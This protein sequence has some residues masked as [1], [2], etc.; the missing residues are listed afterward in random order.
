MDPDQLDALISRRRLAAAEREN[1]RLRDALE[2]AAE[3]EATLR[4]IAE[5]AEKVCNTAF[6]FNVKGVPQQALG[7]V[8]HE[9]V[10]RIGRVFKDELQ[11]TIDAFCGVNLN[12]PTLL[13]HD[14]PRYPKA[15]AALAV[16]AG[17]EGD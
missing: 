7:G 12:D 6:V 15:R 10:D 16:A 1:A 8:T 11:A 14:N 4:K 2:A 9:N 17:A 5:A 13:Y 3:R